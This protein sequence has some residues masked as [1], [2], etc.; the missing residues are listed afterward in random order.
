MQLGIL[1][2]VTYYTASRI[3]S[4]RARGVETPIMVLVGVDIIEDD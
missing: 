4:T 1:P 3:V 2:V